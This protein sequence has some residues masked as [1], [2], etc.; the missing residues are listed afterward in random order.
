V[1]S[2]A[3]LTVLRL[4]NITLTFSSLTGVVVS[5]LCHKSKDLLVQN[6]DNVSD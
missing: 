6:Q 2:K 1:P 3:C 4:P 5:V